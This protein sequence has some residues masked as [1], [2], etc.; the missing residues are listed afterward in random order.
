MQRTT[1]G[2]MI[3][4]LGLLVL[5]L[6]FAAAAEPGFEAGP[7]KVI[8]E[9]SELTMQAIEGR[10]GELREDR[11]ALF[12]IVDEVLLPRWDRSATG[13]AVMGRYW[14]E[15]TPEQ[16]EAFIDGLY[17]KLLESYGEGILEYESDQL[18]ITGTRGDPEKGLAV[19]D[20]EVRMRDGTV[21]PVSYR[22]R[23]H[24][25]SWKVFDVIVEGISYLTTY[26][27]QYASEFRNKGI[28]QVIDEL[29]ADGEQAGS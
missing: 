12:A 1:T 8:R 6:P 22:L 10:R 19:V 24:D 3:L 28:Q 23:L 29:Q 9:A 11:A 13:Q 17:R 2:W 16:R 14:R 4:A 21:V 15:A 18:N 25:G 7:E 27:N 5:A 26:R 20:S